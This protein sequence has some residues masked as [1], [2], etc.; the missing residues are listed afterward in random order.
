MSRRILFSLNKPE[1]NDLLFG[2]CI[3]KNKIFYGLKGSDSISKSK[4][5]LEKLLNIIASKDVF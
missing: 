2:L 4:K 3:V 5:Y 1:N